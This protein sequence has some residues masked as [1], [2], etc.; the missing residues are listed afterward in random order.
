MQAGAGGTAMRRHPAPSGKSPAV[1]SRAPRAVVTGGGL[2]G[3]AAALC[4]AE[5]GWSVTLLEAGPQFAAGWTSHTADDEEWDAGLRVPAESGI[6]WADDLLFRTPP[7]APR[8]NRLGRIARE[9]AITGGRLNPETGCLDA[10]VLP[11]AARAAIQDELLARAEAPDPGPSAPDAAARLATMYGPTLAGGLLAEACRALLGAPPD[12]LAWSATSGRLPERVVVT[13]APRTDALRRI[14]RLAE[15]VAHPSA[16]HIPIAPEER[17]YLYPRQGGIGRWSA[18][19]LAGL[20]AAGV[21]TRLRARVTLAEERSGTLAGLALSEGGRIEAELYVLATAP[22][23]LPLAEP[24]AAPQPGAKPIA[25][26][27]LRFEGGEAPD[28][29]WITSFDSTTPFLRLGFPQRLRGG[30]GRPRS[31]TMIAELHGEADPAGLPEALRPLGLLPGGARLAAAIPIAQGR[32]AQDTPEAE[33]IR[34]EGLAR[35]A[36]FPNLATVGAAAGG[37]VLIPRLIADAAQ[38]AEARRA[39]IAPSRAAHPVHAAL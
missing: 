39:R 8:W 28:L 20:A 32:F 14:G 23:A 15:R 16:R 31:W 10:R 33:R 9:G 7:G 13:D 35:L 17:S 1:L 4:L 29:H 6:A 18:S 37:H 2:G 30:H 27:G 19:L 38:L 3:I 25:A 34:R 12:G 24:V 26:W 22:A 36:A 5:A 21:E 11:A